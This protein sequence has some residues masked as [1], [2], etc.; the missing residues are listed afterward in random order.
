MAHTPNRLEAVWPRLKPLLQQTWPELSES[1]WD[2][3]DHE[4]D[5]LVK[6][7]RQRYGGRAAIMQ[8]AAIRQRV[9]LLLRQIEASGSESGGE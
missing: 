9:N 1:D 5:R 4:F 8:E 2:Y 7:V 6:T 3:V